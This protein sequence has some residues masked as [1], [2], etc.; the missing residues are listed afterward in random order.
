M[1]PPRKEIVIKA[2]AILMADFNEENG[3]LLLH[4]DPPTVDPGTPETLSETEY[5]LEM[6]K[7]S[8]VQHIDRLISDIR[9]RQNIAAPIHRLPAE[10]FVTILNHLAD[11]YFVEGK[12]CWMLKVMT[13][14]R[15]WREAIINSPR[16][17]RVIQLDYPLE[18]A[19]RVFEYCKARPLSLVWDAP[20]SSQLDPNSEQFE[21]VMGL[22]MQNSSRLRS[23]NVVM[24]YREVEL[25]L[26]S[27]LGE[28]TPRLESL[29]IESSFE[30]EDMGWEIETSRFPLSG[31]GPMKELV[32]SGASLLHWDSQRLSGLR[33]LDLERITP[34][35]T[36]NQI[37]RI[38]STSPLLEKFRLAWLLSPEDTLTN[39]SEESL[40]PGERLIGLPHLTDIHLHTLPPLYYSSI[41]SRIRLG[42]CSTVWV[43]DFCSETRN[44]SSM[45]SED[46]WRTRSDTMAALLQLPEAGVPVPVENRPRYITI[47]W[48]RVEITNDD[49][50]LAK[51]S[52]EGS[53]IMFFPYSDDPQ[54]CI[55]ILG[56]FFSSRFQTSPLSLRLKHSGPWQNQAIG[57]RQFGSF[58]TSLR[59]DS[60][61]L[62]RIM[63]KQLGEQ[64]MAENGTPTWF[65]PNL[66]S[67][68]LSYAD[69]EVED[70]EEMDGMGL[71]LAVQRR[72]SG[73]HC[74]APA[75]QPSTFRVSLGF[76]Y[77]SSIMMRAT[78]IKSIV[79]A[80]ELY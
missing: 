1:T 20:R 63:Q 49:Q 46:L 47:E 39:H 28:P 70:D 17:W 15:I 19:R 68:E 76:R 30:M 43:A 27:L 42:L 80:F 5:R 36:A 67:I 55:D 60:H 26:Q 24:H 40:G 4:E 59:V 32:L 29:R 11:A 18:F 14:N 62:C 54:R 64:Y 12:N 51:R 61:P 21:G 74:I 58:L 10:I 16:L 3:S 45:L 66:L 25:A 73:E 8:I 72:W 69:E 52:R 53:C 37:V 31:H 13:V 38:L 77:I 7:S 6:A 78:M 79:P 48:G 9:H 71:L 56:Q 35:P 33:V 2:L 57:L 65:C 44:W 41:L 50:W 23:V 22:A 75:P 34:G